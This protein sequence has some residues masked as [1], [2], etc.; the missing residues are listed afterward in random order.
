MYSSY[1]KQCQTVSE[2]I[3]P[4]PDN[5]NSQAECHYQPRQQCVDL[6]VEQCQDTPREVCH[7]TPEKICQGTEGSWI[8][9]FQVCIILKFHFFTSQPSAMEYLK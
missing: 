3:C 9:I 8:T 4:G 6:P 1:K 2:K 5:Y 7:H